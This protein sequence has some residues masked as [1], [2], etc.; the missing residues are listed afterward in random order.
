[1]AGLMQGLR[2]E[3]SV[4]EK[5]SATQTLG[6]HIR[7][8]AQIVE[9]MY[10]GPARDFWDGIESGNPTDI[11]MA[12]TGFL[13]TG[14]I[15]KVP[16]AMGKVLASNGDNLTKGANKISAL[17]SSEVRAV[18]REASVPFGKSG[19]AFNIGSETELNALFEK[20][21]TE[22]KHVTAKYDG[23]MKVL[24]DGTRIGLRNVSTTGGQTIDV[25]PISGKPYKV[26]VNPE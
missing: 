6:K 21:T 16:K 11:A 26:H 19:Q 24:P 2:G 25:F 17:S 14:A 10:K 9:E 13:P 3:T 18:V 7:T 23:T 4:M 8:G 15:G 5:S 12:A 1:M 22:A 20:I